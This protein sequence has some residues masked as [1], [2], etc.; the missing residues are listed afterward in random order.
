MAMQATPA[1]AAAPVAPPKPPVALDTKKWVDFPLE[2][3]TEINHNTLR[4]R[5]KLPTTNLGAAPPDSTHSLLPLRSP[6]LRSD[7]QASSQASS[8]PCQQIGRAAGWLMALARPRVAC[9]AAGR[10]A[11]LPQGAHRWQARDARVH[12]RRPRPG[13]RRVRHQ[14][15]LP[16]AAP[17]PRG[18]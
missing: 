17:V 2:K 13:L 14:G 7:S 12:S 1:A 9:R 15:L 6:R 18:R 10:E 8:T 11:Y 4:L 5:F 16:A 3:R